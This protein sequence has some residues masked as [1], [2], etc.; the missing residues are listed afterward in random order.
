MDLHSIRNVSFG[1]NEGKRYLMGK[2]VGGLEHTG[3]S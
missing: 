2:G 3:G 1:E